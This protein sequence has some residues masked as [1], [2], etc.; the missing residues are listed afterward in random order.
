VLQSLLE[1]QIAIDVAVV[2]WFRPLTVYQMFV[3]LCSYILMSLS[4]IVCRIHLTIKIDSG[5]E[6]NEYTVNGILK[7]RGVSYI[8]MKG[9]KKLYYSLHKYLPNFFIKS[10]ISCQVCSTSYWLKHR[11]LYSLS[12]IF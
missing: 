6:A 5:S 7:N 1:V 12:D 9:E 8:Y 3:A 10:D 2:R 4:L 11:G